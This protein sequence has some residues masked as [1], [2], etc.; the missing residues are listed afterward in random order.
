M[1]FLKYTVPLA[2]LITACEAIP[3]PVAR[4]PHEKR[5]SHHDAKWRR[6]ARVKRDA[7]IP[8]RIGLTQ[9]E[10]HNGYKYL[11]DV[12]HPASPNFGK[13]WTPEEVIENFSPADETVEAVRSWLVESGIDYNQVVHSDNR[14]WLALDIPV[15]EAERLFETEYYEHENAGIEGVRIG[16]D[17]YHIPEH[18]SKHIDYVTPGVK[19]SNLLKRRTV[20]RTGG[21]AKRNSLYGRAFFTH[22]AV[23]ITP[24]VEPARNLSHI[25]EDV[26]DCA[27][28]ITL[29][30][31]K[32]LYD[33]PDPRQTPDKVNSLGIFEMGDTYAQEDLN[34]YFAQYASRVP[35]GTH[36]IPAF[37]DNGTAPVPPDSP[38]NT[39]ESDIDMDIAFSLI[40]P[41]TVTLYQ[42]DP[43]P[44][45]DKV[46]EG[47]LNTFLDALDGSYCTYTADGITGDSPGIDPTYPP[48]TLQCGVYT[49]T[50]VITGSYGEAEADLPQNYQQRQCNEFM[51]LG[52]Q[53]HSIFFSSGDY[54]VGGNP[55]DVYADGSPSSCSNNVGPTLFTPQNPVNCPYITAVGGTRLYPGQD[56]KDAESVMQANLGPGAE[57]FG[58]GGGFANYFPRPDYQNEAVDAYFAAY[59]PGYPTYTV[60]SNGSNVGEN[61][62]LYNRGGRGIPDVSANGALMPAYNDET[63]FHFYGTSLSS[64]IWASVAT[65]LNEERTYH[66][67]GPIGF[68]NPVLYANAPLFNDIVNGSNP[69][70]GTPGFK[71]VPGWD[72]VTG[73][74]TPHFNSLKDL[75]LSLP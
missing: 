33:I 49:P 41:Q 55:A 26:R 13:H 31:W 46:I 2:L 73:L 29:P 70:C 27:N 3:A 22:H 71:A 28:N 1:R 52:L 53:G 44:P 61:G 11:M 15:Y 58:T 48:G 59:D 56:V 21:I 7:I 24:D 54:G 57:L 8:I 45:T 36:P 16:C 62:G 23:E 74:G 32:A 75:Y 25:P 50:R 17:N 35:Q 20:Q 64:P 65:L 63:L 68:M 6:S 42:V 72:P 38:A 30:C 51:K 60:N 12:S 69:G 19:F 67:K 9:T 39:G 66:G 4:V 40:Y 37:V 43:G 34:L 47:W 14:G 5:T 18:L 10:L